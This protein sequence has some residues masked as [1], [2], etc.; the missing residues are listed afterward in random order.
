MIA[1]AMFT[2]A[3]LSCAIWIHLAIGRGR[4]WRGAENDQAMHEALPAHRRA[5]AGRWPRVVAVIPAR[6]EAEL[7][8]ITVAS[9][10]GQRYEGD[11]SVIVVDD[12]SD[13]GTAE[14]AIAA[15]AG[16]GAAE[17]LTV[18]SAPALPAGWTG[19]L[20]AVSHGVAHADGLS[21][22]PEF[23][24]LTDA[25]IR[26]DGDA[27]AALVSSA[28]ESRL[29]LSSLMVALRCESLAERTLIPAFVF[30]F[31]MLYPFAWVDQPGRRT[32][33]AAGGCTLV[34][35]SALQAAGGI[36][37]IRDALIDDCALAGRLK[38]QG[39]IRLALGE[40]V[41]S[42]RAYPAFDDV[43]RMVVR[44]AY[45]QLR[46]SPSLLLLVAATMLVVFIAPVVLTV[47]GDGWTRAIAGFTWALMALLF[48][49]ISRRYR[50]PAWWSVMLPA[51][52]AVYLGFTIESAVQH[53]LGR[54]GM[55]KG[56]ANTPTRAFVRKRTP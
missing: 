2:T 7:V 39:P 37:S 53:S 22:P 48:V 27:V 50:V 42:L 36:A 23:L 52:A 56:R 3:A 16:A 6:N 34:R 35:R 13:D 10:L 43:R 11:L 40:H 5:R 17:R 21:N 14:V 55:W 33:A 19:K 47:A 8:G 32:A 15:A 25:D 41:Q 20:W 24:L 30:F 44:S 51:V 12:H 45:A 54:G 49:P 29:V 31:Q 4:F 9:L 26:Y 28:V 18:L 38:P 46:F 1:L